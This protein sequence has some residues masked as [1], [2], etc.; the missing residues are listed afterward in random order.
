VALIAKTISD[1]DYLPVPKIVRPPSENQV[2]DV[3]VVYNATVSQLNDAV[4]AP[5]FW[6][7]SA[8]TALRQLTFMFFVVDFDL[9]EMFLNFALPF[10]LRKFVRELSKAPS[11]VSQ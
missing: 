3:R 1:V 2:L 5:K 10:F 4:W 9:G 7:P 8:D 11:R 6:L